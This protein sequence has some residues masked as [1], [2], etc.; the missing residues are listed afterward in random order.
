V[1]AELTAAIQGDVSRVVAIGERWRSV[2][3]AA[4]YHRVLPLIGK[5]VLALPAVPEDV[6]Q[7]LA[8]R[9]RQTAIGEAVREAE[10]K[11]LLAACHEASIQALI[12]KG[13]AL[14]YTCY[15]GPELRPRTDTDLLVDSTAR[16]PAE[17][18]LLALGYEAAAGFSGDLVSYQAAYVKR[19]AGVPVHVVDLHWRIANPQA[20]GEILPFDDAAAEAVGVP[21]LG[22]GARALSPVHALLVACVH[23]VAHHSG[24]ARLI[25]LVDISRIAAVLTTEDWARFQWL[26]RDRRVAAVCRSGLAEAARLCAAPVPGDVIEA[27]EKRTDG[28]EPTAAFLKRRRHAAVVAQDLAA[29]PSWGGRVKLLRQHALPSPAYMRDVYAP[30]SRLP[31]AVLYAKRALRGGWKWLLRG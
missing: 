8:A 13:A 17:Q 10:L 2:R 9:A 4:E 31:L 12:F 1:T 29:L 25:W 19:R 16:T 5:A 7:E 3:S 11:A 26:A 24:D 18:V 14:A 15:D 6:R 21:A 28:H 23:R 20:F 22:P 27:L 30:G